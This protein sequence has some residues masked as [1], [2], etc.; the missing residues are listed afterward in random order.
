V[1]KDTYGVKT[2]IRGRELPI[3]LNFEDKKETTS[4][5]VFLLNIL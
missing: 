4:I 1:R 2:T 3:G 5:F